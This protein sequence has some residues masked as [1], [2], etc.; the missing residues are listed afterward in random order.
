MRRALKAKLEYAR[1]LQKTLD[2]MGPMD[3]GHRSQSASDFVHFYNTVK[4]TG[5]VENQVTNKDILKFSK[6]FEDEITLDNMTRGQLVAIV[7]LLELTPLGTNNFLRFQIEMQLRKLKA[8]DVIIAKEGVENLNVAEL[9]GA[10]KDRGMRALGLTKEK[11][12]QQLKEWIELSTNNKVPPSLLLL[13]RTLYLPESLDSSSKIAATISALP[14]TAVMGAK[15]KIGSME[16]KIENVTQLEIIKAEQAKIEEEA[17]DKAKQTADKKKKEADDK[18]KA[19]KLKQEALE[20]AIEEQALGVVPETAPTAE[21]VVSEATGV[22]RKATVTSSGSME[23]SDISETISNA[24]TSDDI[25]VGQPQV[26]EII[27]EAKPPIP[28]ALKTVD[29]LSTEDL[30]ALRS[31]IETISTEKGSNFIVEN[32]VLT[33]LKQELVDYQEDLGELSETATKAGRNDLKQTKGAARLFKRVNK[34]LNKMD[35][36]VNNLEAREKKL[37]ANINDPGTES[38]D[39]KGHLVTVQGI[40]QA[41]RG[42]QDVPDSAR[43]ERI[44][45]VVANMDDDSDGVV[46]VDHVN[47]VV[48][49]LGRDN[50][51]L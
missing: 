41:V 15:A 35:G 31:A 28:A 34:M 9:Q 36:L 44:S 23:H 45:E 47:K 24:V 51:H 1:F 50:L 13:S 2:D 33:E 25:H 21:R 46:K 12:V 6:L 29:D 42:L 11:L 19:D 3:K 40:L 32:E 22:L 30:E 20:T 4:K 48:E 18:A 27:E 10:C 5:A 37:S 16:G 17:K 38:E 26:M 39:Q 43:L 14:D 49:I 7:K 8:D